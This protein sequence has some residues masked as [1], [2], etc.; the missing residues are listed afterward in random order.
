MFSQMSILDLATVTSETFVPFVGQGFEMVFSDAR[1]SF[2]LAEVR[3]LGPARKPDLRAPFAVVFRG[4]PSLRLPQRIYR[5]ENASLGAM[6]I[7]LVQIGDGAEGSL[8]EAIFN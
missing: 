6:E 7:F 3:P 5:L 8:F 2:T 4:R 1:L